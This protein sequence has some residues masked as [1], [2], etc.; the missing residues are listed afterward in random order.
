MVCWKSPGQEDDPSICPGIERV[1]AADAD[2]DAA[3]A[4]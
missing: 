4:C 1:A 2:E 3:A